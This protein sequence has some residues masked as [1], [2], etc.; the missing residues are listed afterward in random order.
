M[1]TC[2]VEAG[3]PKRV[4]KLLTKLMLIFDSLMIAMV[5]PVPLSG[6]AAL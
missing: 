6:L 4:R 3:S 5:W 2:G 1:I